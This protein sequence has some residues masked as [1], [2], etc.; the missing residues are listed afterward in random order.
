MG[1]EDN[2]YKC[3]VDEDKSHD[4]EAHD[5]STWVDGMGTEGHVWSH[6]PEKWKKVGKIITLIVR[7]TVIVS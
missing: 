7:T 4:L 5:G 3:N 1:K 6:E 2:A